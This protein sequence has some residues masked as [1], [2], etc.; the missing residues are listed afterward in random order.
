MHSRARAGR[1]VSG[2]RR[3]SSGILDQS[4]R[5]GPWPSSLVT[6]GRLLHLQWPVC[7]LQAVW[8]TGGA[9]NVVIADSPGD[10]QQVA[11]AREPA[12]QRRPDLC[13]IITLL[14]TRQ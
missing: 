14:I 8:W 13:H 7:R 1:E 3:Y 10:A 9:K 4:L 5:M 6:Q 2:R 12:Q 11:T